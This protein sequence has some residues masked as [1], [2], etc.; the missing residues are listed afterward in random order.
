ML[1]RMVLL[2]LLA[3]LLCSTRIYAT[4]PKQEVVFSFDFNKRFKLAANQFAVWIENDKGELIKTLFV[5]AFTAGKGWEK[6]PDALVAWRKAVQEKPVDAVS[7]A[8]PKSGRQEFVWEL[9]DRAGNSVP[10]GK[11]K[12]RL[13]ANAAWKTY[14]EYECTISVNNEEILL[15]ETDHKI[16][17]KEPLK[18]KI[19]SNITIETR[20]S[21]K[22]NKKLQCL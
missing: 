4:T 3:V 13:E 1:K 10:D 8:T 14:F 2:I 20:I 18:Q 6:R 17:G 11:Y 21:G 12:L 16:T 7:G 5:T 9:D 15:G 19:V 22:A